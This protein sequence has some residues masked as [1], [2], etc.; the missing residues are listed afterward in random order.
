MR[1]ASLL[2]VLAF[3]PSLASADATAGATASPGRLALGLHVGSLQSELDADAGY[4]AQTEYGLFARYALDS[5]IGA[6]VDIAK[7][8]MRDVDDLDASSLSVAAVFDIIEGGRLVPTV[9]VG[10][11]VEFAEGT[12]YQAFA[13]RSELGL[14]L[15]L[16]GASGVF[17][18]ID[19]RIGNRSVT[20]AMTP[21]ILPA[22]PDD[23]FGTRDGY[24]PS[25]LQPG[26]FRTVRLVG[27]VRF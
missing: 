21:S 22:Y 8:T 9:F 23:D 12:D 20:E 1:F 2:V 5:R 24:Q 19:A 25:R 6:Q 16:R 15:E 18:G 11:G 7:L 17:L 26:Q 14:G 13:R 27:G 10:M 3:V 4:D